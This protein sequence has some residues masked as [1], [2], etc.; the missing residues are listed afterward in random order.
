MIKT[1]IT[2][3]QKISRG[4][5]MFF[6]KV[7]KNVSITLY[8]QIIHEPNADI[9]AE[10]IL[11]RFSDE[12]GAYKRTY[13]K[14]FEDFDAQVVEVLQQYFNVNDAL[15]IQDVGVSDGRTSVDFF[16][17]LI[18][19]F[20]NINLNA[21]DFNPMVYILEKNH[22]KVTLSHTKKV[23]EI[24]Y[25]PFVF[26][27][28][29]KECYWFYPLNY[30]VLFLV[31]KFVV[32]PLLKLYQAEK[33]QAKELLLF[34]PASLK[35]ANQ[36]LRFQLS[37]HNLLTPFKNKNHIIRAMN[38]L[39]P[40]YFSKAEFEILLA[41]M[42]AGLLDGGLLITGSNQEAGTTV[43]GGMYQKSE[44]GFQQIWKSGNGSPIEKQILEFKSI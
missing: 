14:R 13:A 2:N 1:G 17:K 25:P 21:S 35:L 30:L 19:I 44:M 26:N 39:N 40:P 15:S 16:E 10:R 29:K 18:F 9:L 8:D 11:L 37:Q 22:I 31:N 24:A 38:V 20:S 33:I 42:H 27:A 32:G 7:L 4:D 12:R 28:I 36:D 23:L 6:N 41:N 34:A 3:I 43:H 5:R